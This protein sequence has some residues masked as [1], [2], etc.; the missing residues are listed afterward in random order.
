[1]PKNKYTISK[2]DQIKMWKAANREFSTK[3]SPSVVHKTS[4]K[5]FIDRTDNSLSEEEVEEI[6]ED[7][8]YYYDKYYYDE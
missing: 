8:F 5:D 1:M 6:L 4:K 3:Y 7:E 2:E